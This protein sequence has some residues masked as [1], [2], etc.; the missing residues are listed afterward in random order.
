MSQIVPPQTPQAGSVSGIASPS[1]PAAGQIAPPGA[2]NTS[3]V[4]AGPSHIHAVEP[5]P[6]AGGGHKPPFDIPAD[7]DP[8][9]A[10]CKILAAIP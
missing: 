5:V 7:P 1:K 10:L 4:G 3:K 2:P 8:D 6:A 9:K